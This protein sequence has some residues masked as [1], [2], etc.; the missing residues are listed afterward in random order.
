MRRPPNLRSKKYAL[1]SLLLF[2]CAVS[3]FSQGIRKHYTQLT[4][5]ERAAL[6]AAIDQLM[7]SGIQEYFAD[8][9]TDPD[10]DGNPG[11]NFNGPD[12]DSQIHRVAIFLSWHR[13]FTVEYERRLQ[14]IDPRL[15]IPYWDWTGDFDPVGVNSRSALS[16]IW[17]NNQVAALGWTTSLLGK[18]DNL[19]NLNRGLGGALPTSAQKQNLITSSAFNN[20]GNF[21]FE[22]EVNLHDPP[23]G[24]VGGE[25][26]DMYY[27]P[28]DPAFFMHHAMVDYLWQLWTEDGHSVS[29]TQTSMPTFDGSVAGFDRIDPDDIRNTVTQMGIFY[30]NPDMGHFQLE[31]YTVHNDHLPV[32]F[33]VYPETIEVEPTFQI[34]A[35][36]DVE[37]H[38]CESVVLKPGFKILA[39]ST[40]RIGT[41]GFCDTPA[42]RADMVAANDR[43]A[44]Q[45]VQ[46]PD[47]PMTKAEQVPERVTLKGFPNPFEQSFTFQFNIPTEEKVSMVLMDGLGKVVATPLPA[48]LRVA[49]EH[50]VLVDAQ[51]LPSGMYSAVLLLH[52]TNQRY[53]LR[54]VKA[55]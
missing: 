20:F 22:L 47:K 14:A 45:P 8:V 9:H 29:F 17:N 32:E 7:Q 15:T 23:H 51:A 5:A 4:E 6:V 40:A 25:M 41:N 38:S 3:G 2:L 50:E 42:A 44:S 48:Q 27:S 26:Q 21:R 37:I 10:Q 39:G 16:P 55:D 18:Y 49:G 30:A 36:A 53:V 31:N 24:W 1:L 33:F 34:A 28:R 52:N 54:V 11:N 35:G 19:N 46:Q 13:Q 12:T 43:P